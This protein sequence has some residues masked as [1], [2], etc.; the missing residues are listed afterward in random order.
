M[1]FQFAFGDFYLHRKKKSSRKKKEKKR[2]NIKY[3]CE[4]DSVS[5]CIGVY[6]FDCLCALREC[7]KIYTF[8]IYSVVSYGHSWNTENKTKKKKK[9]QI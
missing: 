7:I 3:S 9:K 4:T 6:G 8:A 1:Q 2:N 5:I